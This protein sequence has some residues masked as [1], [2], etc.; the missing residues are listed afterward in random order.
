MARKKDTPGKGKKE[1]NTAAA[2]PVS[3]DA[4]PG[5]SPAPPRT[6]GVAP[7][8]TAS[9][10][11]RGK[12]AP[13]D[14]PR[15]STGIVAPSLEDSKGEMPIA[16][17][18]KPTPSTTGAS[19]TPGPK[20]G[21]AYKGRKDPSRRLPPHLKAAADRA[22]AE[23]ARRRGEEAPVRPEAARDDAEAEKP[24]VAL[25]PEIERHDPSLVPMSLIERHTLAT[26]GRPTS[27]E[28]EFA[29]I[30]KA[31]CE[32]G[33]T[34]W[35]LA[36]RFGV[37]RPTINRWKLEHAEF[38]DSVRLGKDSANENVKRSFY[39]LAVGYNFEKVELHSFQGQVT[40]TTVT[41]HIPP[42]LGA[43]KAFLAARVPDEFGKI[44]DEAAARKREAEIAAQAAG[45]TAIEIA[46][47]IAYLLNRGA[48]A[49]I[50]GGVIDATATPA[51]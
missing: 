30:A 16:D 1:P 34:D 31:M 23:I 42:N 35:D 45:M 11:A 13:T 19:K 32:A 37:A 39:E 46:R 47:R 36:L 12:D 24:K 27:Y 10:E 51:K 41:E 25:D 26:K 38:R 15:E 4:T 5:V 7:D 44:D 33:A 50:Q 20:G 8:V 40:Q 3:V 49:A 14:G 9:A 6:P 21:G 48:Q 22:E 18:M 2:G 17:A 29:E 43:I 28:P